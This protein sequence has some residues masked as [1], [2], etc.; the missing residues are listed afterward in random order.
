MQE[1][2]ERAR[3]YIHKEKRS[4]NSVVVKELVK[5]QSLMPAKV[6]RRD[7]NLDQP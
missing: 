1:R 3:D 6:R 7:L 5:A 2:A 4:I